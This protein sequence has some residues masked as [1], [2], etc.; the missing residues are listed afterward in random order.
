MSKCVLRNPEIA[1]DVKVMVAHSHILPKG[2][3]AAGLWPAVTKGDQQ[4]ITRVITDVYR[5]ADGCSRGPKDIAENIKSDSQVIADLG[6]LSPMCRVV[7]AR[8]RMLA[9]ILSRLGRH[10]GGSLCGQA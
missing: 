5:A 9:L 3:F 7:F 10:L 1:V 6:I 2:E 4:R 8:V